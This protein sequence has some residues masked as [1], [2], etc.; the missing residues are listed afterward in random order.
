MSVP[1]FFSGALPKDN[2]FSYVLYRNVALLRNFRASNAFGESCSYQLLAREVTLT[3]YIALFP[4]YF[5]V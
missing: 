4:H 5:A 1:G 3:L 2:V